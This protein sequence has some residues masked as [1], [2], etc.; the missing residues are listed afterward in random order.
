MG[1]AWIIGLV[2]RLVGG[3]MYR[4]EG[5]GLVFVRGGWVVKGRIL[6]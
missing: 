5:I 2:M 6:M 1:Y 3:I 4:R